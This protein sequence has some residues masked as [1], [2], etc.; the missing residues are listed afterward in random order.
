MKIQQLITE[1]GTF[2]YPFRVEHQDREN[3]IITSDSAALKLYFSRYRDQVEI[4]FSVGKRFLMTGQGNAFRI[5]STVLNMLEA[6]LGDFIQEQDSI[7][8]FGSEKSEPSRVS[9]YTR[10]VPMISRI[11]GRDWQYIDTDDSRSGLKTFKWVRESILK[12]KTPL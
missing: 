4:E 10:A 2:S 6:H 8:L 1:L 9:L 3:M 11:L 7:V 12:P 5:L